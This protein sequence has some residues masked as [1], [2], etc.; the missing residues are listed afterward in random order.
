MWGFG[1]VWLG[2]AL[3][4]IAKCRPF[5][6]NMGWWGEHHTAASCHG[7]RTEHLSQG[8]TF[9]LGVFAASTLQIG[10]ELPS[11]A[12]KIFGTVRLCNFGQCCSLG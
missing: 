10:L 9:P 3:I 5:P 4:I 6:F 1:L 12:F 11:E 2:L 8:F 7:D